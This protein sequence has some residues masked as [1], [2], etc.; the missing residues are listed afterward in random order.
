MNVAIIPARGESKRIPRKNIKFFSGKP[1][2]AYSI[3]AALKSKCF[4]R[5]LVSTDDDEVA[6]IA[7][8]YGAE[9]PFIRPVGLASDRVGTLA[10]IQHALYSIAQAGAPAHFACCIYAAAPFVAP[11]DLKRGLAMLE[12]YNLDFSFSVTSYPYP[13]QRALR[14]TQERRVQMFQPNH[15]ARS[16]HFEPAF[17]DAG[18]FYW[19]RAEAFEKGWPVFSERSMAVFM[20]RH[21]VPYIGTPEEWIDAELLY[22]MHSR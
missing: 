9:I 4:D 11:D 14:L 18:Q 7:A 8:R 6:D 16:Q 20:P 22:R 13:I 12:R 3:E 21:R 5:V 15:P 1:V 19:G 2:I 17:H 10:V